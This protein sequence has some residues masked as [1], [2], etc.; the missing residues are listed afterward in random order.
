CPVASDRRRTAAWQKHQ[1][2]YARRA[3]RD[4]DWKP[5]NRSIG[6]F[7]WSALRVIDQRHSCL[8]SAYH[9]RTALDPYGCPRARPGALTCWLDG[10]FVRG[11]P[12][13]N[14]G[15]PAILVTSCLRIDDRLP[16]RALSVPAL[17]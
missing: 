10:C 1:F 17:R 13:P 11:G 4:F 12:Q 14:R 16:P 9:D 5:D 8:G 2:V 3:R 7:T 6:K 15:G